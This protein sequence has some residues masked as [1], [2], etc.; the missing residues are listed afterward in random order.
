MLYNSGMAKRNFTLT[1]QEAQALRARHDR[2]KDGPTRSRYQAVWMYGT[3]YPVAEIEKLVGCSRSSLMNWCRTYLERGPV[4][5]EDDRGGGNN[6]KLSAAQ[7]E[8]LQTRLQSYTPAQVFGPQAATPDGQF[9]TVAD[10][11]RAV[12]QWYGVT[13]RSPTSYRQLLLSSG[14]SYQR[15]AKVFKSRRPAQVAEFE[16]AFEK[17]SSTSSKTHRTP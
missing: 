1:K 8:D 7:R 2:T 16:A 15:P 12:E 10:V 5:L 17:K 4:G 13:Y 6:R 3:G 9:W 14:F 11:Y